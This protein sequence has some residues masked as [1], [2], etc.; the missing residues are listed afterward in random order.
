VNMEV[1]KIT[2]K[3][4]VEAYNIKQRAW[5][6]GRD[7]TTGANKYAESTREFAR[8][9]VEKL[10]KKVAEL[11]GGKSIERWARTFIKDPKD[12]P[13]KTPTATQDVVKKNEEK[14][15]PRNP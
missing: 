7:I 11:P 4:E 15:K 10:L 14:W 5:K 12:Q 3:A 9:F 6:V 13:V 8:G 2:K 1:K